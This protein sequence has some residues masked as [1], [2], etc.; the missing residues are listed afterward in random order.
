M[1]DVIRSQEGLQAENYLEQAYHSG[2]IDG[3]QYTI[4]LDIHANAMYYNQD[5]LSK[6]GVEH[7]LDDDVVTFDELLSLQG[8]LEDGDYAVNDSLISW[9][10]L[11]QIQNLGGD[12]E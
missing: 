2:N 4:P 11:A 12:I 7:F 5:L 1:T 6:Y 9:V 8:K 10:I 3:V